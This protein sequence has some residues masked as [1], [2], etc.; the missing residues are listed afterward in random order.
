M[1][2][3]KKFKKMQRRKRK[4]E[5]KE[6]KRK[7]ALRKKRKQVYYQEIN[8][9]VARLINNNPEFQALGIK[10]YYKEEWINN[11]KV[12]PGHISWD[13]EQY[14][15]STLICGDHLRIYEKIEGKWKA[16][17]QYNPKLV[18]M[19]VKLRDEVYK[20]VKGKSIN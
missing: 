18:N 9:S 13:N 4:E 5:R 16:T 12:Q 11:F 6:K 19:L 1:T 8:K 2:G 7:K 20:S 3:Q 14:F 10:A 15:S 17:W